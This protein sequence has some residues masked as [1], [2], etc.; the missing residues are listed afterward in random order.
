MEESKITMNRFL[1][2]SFE[3]FHGWARQSCFIFNEA[4]GN[5][6]GKPRKA[7][8]NPHI[9]TNFKQKQKERFIHM[10]TE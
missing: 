10:I 6:P 8:K 7:I 9:K 5:L 2:F 4:G 1:T 3:S